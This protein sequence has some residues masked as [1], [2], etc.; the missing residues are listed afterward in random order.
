VNL[1]FVLSS[2]K[3]LKDNNNEAIVHSVNMWMLSLLQQVKPCCLDL[4]KMSASAKRW[5]SIFV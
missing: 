2:L 1:F 4:T 5:E 3:G